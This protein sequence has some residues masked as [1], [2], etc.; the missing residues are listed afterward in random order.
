MKYD[1]DMIDLIVGNL[2]AYPPMLTTN[3]LLELGIFNSISGAAIMR[4]RGNG[5]KCVKIGRYVLYPKENILDFLHKQL[6][7][8]THMESE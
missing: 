3:D 8:I 4:Y 1:I 2:D 5:P 7:N 6:K